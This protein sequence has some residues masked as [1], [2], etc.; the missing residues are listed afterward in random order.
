MGSQLTFDSWILYLDRGK[1]ERE[2]K[3]GG[4]KRERA[5]GFI[6]SYKHV[7][8]CLLDFN[9]EDVVTYKPFV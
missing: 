1:A 8:L 5:I 6:T 9:R 2:T 7:V 3:H 4:H